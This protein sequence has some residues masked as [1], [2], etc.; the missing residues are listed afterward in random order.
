MGIPV[1]T[2]E[3]IE[4]RTV[5][6]LFYTLSNGPP[7]HRQL[8]KE[9]FPEAKCPAAPSNFTPVW[10]LCGHTLR[11]RHLCSSGVRTNTD[12]GGFYSSVSL[13]SVK[14]ILGRGWGESD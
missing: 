2:C 14:E 1:F 13:F 12:F 3:I 11:L 9:L 4:S 10:V 7:K 8:S 6:C 5:G